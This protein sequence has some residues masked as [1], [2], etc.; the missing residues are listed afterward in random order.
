MIMRRTK[1]REFV[2][3]LWRINALFL[4]WARWFGRIVVRTSDLRLAGSIPGHD[5]AWLF[6]HKWQSLAGKV[7]WHITITQVNSALHSSMVVKPS[8]SFGWGKGGKVTAGESDLRLRTDVGFTYL[9]TYFI[10]VLMTTF[11]AFSHFSWFYFICF[12][13]P[14]Q[15]SI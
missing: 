15:Y 12:N 4:C 10:H 13:P 3:C 6:W 9:L 14:A 8:T 7:S 1:R 5:T 2:S 11:R